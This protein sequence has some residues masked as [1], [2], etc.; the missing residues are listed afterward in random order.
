MATLLEI[1]QRLSSRYGQARKLSAASPLERF[2]GAVLAPQTSVARVEEA[3]ANLRDAGVLDPGALAGLAPAEL[4]ELIRPVGHVRVKAQRL[5]KLLK[6]FEQHYASSLEDMFA[7]DRQTLRTELQAMNGIGPETADTILLYGGNLP[8]YVVDTH[9]NRVLKR[10]GL[11][12][13]E[14]DYQEVQ[15]YVEYSIDR[16][17]ALFR[18]L[19]ALLA[20]VGAEHCG[21]T[22]DC[23]DCPLAELLPE[24]GPLEPPEL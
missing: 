3:L 9:A 19:H 6:F 10:H 15:E 18:E 2:V 11:L 20:R 1:Y 23:E 5:R 12:E 17:P 7:A 13:F 14:A 21:K 24:S 16:D 8:S 22:P 4:E